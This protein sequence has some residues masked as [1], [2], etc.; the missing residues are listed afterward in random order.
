MSRP[1][2]Q[3]RKMGQSRARP[4]SH[5]C[6]D[7]RHFAC[8]QLAR[9]RAVDSRIA[10]TYGVSCTAFRKDASMSSAGLVHS[11]SSEKCATLGVDPRETP[12]NW[13]PDCE[14]SSAELCPPNSAGIR[15]ETFVTRGMSHHGV[16]SHT[17][18]IIFES[19]SVLTGVDDAT[20]PSTSGQNCTRC[21]TASSVNVDTPNCRAL[22]WIIMM[23]H[24][25]A[26]ISAHR[27]NTISCAAF[28]CTRDNTFSTVTIQDTRVAEKRA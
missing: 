2:Y 7:S 26:S 11:Q 17:V 6:F 3:G 19:F 5:P 14:Q 15:F 8:H 21:A 22:S 10:N 27:S 13:L 28:G 1:T 20:T 12:L 24:R 4:R 16:C 9:P 25:L 18:R 23:A